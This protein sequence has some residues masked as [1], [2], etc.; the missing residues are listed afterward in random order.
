[1]NVLV[2]GGAGF[3]GS[4][5]CV[6][7]LMLGYKV[8]VLDNLCNSQISALHGVSKITNIDL[9]MEF[10]KQSQFVFYKGD[11]R[12]LEDLEA[13]FSNQRID[14]VIHLAGLK[15]VESSVKNPHEYFTN[16]IGGTKNLINTMIKFNCKSIIFSSSA[17]LYGNSN[18]VPFNEDSNIAP[19]NPYGQSK[20]LIELFLK[21]IF[22]SDKS[23]RIAIL[24]FFNP[25]GAH[26]S[27]TIGENPNETPNNLMPYILS[28]ANKDLKALKIYGNNYNTHDGTGIRDYIHVMDIADAN[29][30]A[31]NVLMKKSQIFTVNLGTGIGYSVLDVV[32]TFEKV[33][34]IKI[35]F[36][37]VPRREGDVAISYSDPSYAKEFFGWKAKYNLEEMCYDSWNFIL[38]NKNKF[39]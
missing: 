6:Q 8:I 21:K 18:M 26:Q 31:F 13:I 17:T 39:D 11:I 7:F 4:H 34:G 15:S 37:I 12:N 3:I 9:E 27:G 25:I 2:S 30:K 14:C 22:Q 19:T 36:Q 35:N 24:R 20:S 16:N 33:S 1:M 29:I 32:K 23:W 5:V 10:Q 28:V 38:K